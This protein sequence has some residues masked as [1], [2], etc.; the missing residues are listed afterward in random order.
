MRV[1]TWGLSDKKAEKALKKEGPEEEKF[2]ILRPSWDFP[3]G[4][5]V[6]TL[7]FHCRGGTGSIPGRGTKIPQAA[8]R[9]Q[10]VK[11]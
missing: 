10:K 4:L 6:K 9:G 1:G 5:V 11:K 3:G 7:C 8:R 2:L